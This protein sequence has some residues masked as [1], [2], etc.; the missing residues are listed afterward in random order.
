[1]PKGGSK[2][3][4]PTA[5]THSLSDKRRLPSSLAPSFKAKA[6]TTGAE[7]KSRATL[8]SF[9][10]TSTASSGGG[11]SITK[12]AKTKQDRHGVSSKVSP[13]VRG[14]KIPP[15]TP[16]TIAKVPKSKTTPETLRKK[17]VISKRSTG[18][19]ASQ[20]LSTKSDESL[21]ESTP[22]AKPFSQR[23][24]IVH[25]PATPLGSLALIPLPVLKISLPGTTIDSPDRLFKKLAQKLHNW[26]MLGRYLEVDDQQLATISLKASDTTESAIRMLKGWLGQSKSLATYTKLGEA[27][28]NCMR[29]DL[30]IILE[31]HSKLPIAGGSDE[32]VTI[33]ELGSSVQEQSDQ[34]EPSTDDD[35]HEESDD[36]SIKMTVP[37]SMLLMMLGPLIEDKKKE[38]KASKVTV[39]LKFH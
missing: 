35:H 23:F 24:D 22:E 39:S 7:P 25:G 1:M 11:A 2:T 13:P 36:S 10:T 6:T 21:K 4:S 29:D 34:K 8:A 15:L 32:H 18:M 37:I 31:Q 12:L 27:L 17:E 14:K 33:E 26:K 5:S 19:S 3:L 30:V 28:V 38:G 16:P 20:S 9:K